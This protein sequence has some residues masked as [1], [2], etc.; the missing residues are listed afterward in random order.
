[1]SQPTVSNYPQH[2]KLERAEGMTSY[3]LSQMVTQ[4]SLPGIVKATLRAHCDRYPNIWPSVETTSQHTGFSPRSTQRANVSLEDDNLINALGSKKGGRGRTI[5]Y[6]VNVEEIKRRLETPPVRQGSETGVENSACE[7]PLT[8]PVGHP[9]TLKGDCESI[10]GDCVAPE[11]TRNLISVLTENI[12]HTT[13]W[14]V[15]WTAKALS[16]SFGQ[17]VTLRPEDKQTIHSLSEEY[18]PLAYVTGVW[19]F[20]NTKQWYGISN[21]A[22]AATV[23]CREIETAIGMNPRKSDLQNYVEAYQEQLEAVTDNLITVYDAAQLVMAATTEED[24]LINLDALKEYIQKAKEWIQAAD[25]IER[26]A[27]VEEWAQE[28]AEQVVKAEEDGDT[29][30]LDMG[31]SLY[32]QFAN[33]DEVPEFNMAG[34]VQ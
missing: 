7:S 32:P 12:N 27:T 33:V 3:K 31:R 15:S 29:S 9:L 13:D 17:V 34:D 23:F 16:T 20:V 26:V 22:G 14:L 25:E 18:G 5:Q 4:L 19:R 1:M 8:P 28:M 30:E 11:H 2:Q 24:D 21:P 6:A 10:K